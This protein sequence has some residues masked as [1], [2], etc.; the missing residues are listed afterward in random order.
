MLP[1]SSLAGLLART[2]FLPV[3]DTAGTSA[4]FRTHPLDRQMRDILVACQHVV[5]QEKVYR[6]AGRMLLGLDPGD[7]FF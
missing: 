7:P 5:V 1:E 6:R 3:Y 4:I 2:G